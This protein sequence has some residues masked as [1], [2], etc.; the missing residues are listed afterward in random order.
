M[1]SLAAATVLLLGLS[2]CASPPGTTTQGCKA[3]GVISVGER[4]PDCRFEVLNGPP[5]ALRSLEDLPTVMNF[6]ASWC[7]ACIKE[8]PA[9]DAAAKDLAGKVRFVGMDVVGIKGETR[10]AAET[11]LRKTP[12]S[13]TIA[14]DD[15]GALYEHFATSKARPIMPVTVFIAPGGIV[16]LRRFGEMSEGE[17]RD[18]IRDSLGVA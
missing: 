4:I 9:L 15:G 11:F 12:V 1:R 18:F 13:Y 6:W 14:F 10:L 16:K 17:I 2:A 5:L 7:I 3:T 8:M